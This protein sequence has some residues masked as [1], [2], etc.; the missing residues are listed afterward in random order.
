MIFLF[1]SSIIALGGLGFL[2]GAGL[3]YASKKF[4]VEVDPKVELVQD[5]LPN[6]NCGACG[7][8]GCAAFAEA[9]VAG[10]VAPNKCTPG[11]S[12]TAQRISDI[13]GVS[14]V[15][16]EEPRVAVLQCQGGNKEAPDKFEY[17][18]INDCQAA[19]MI[20]GGAKAC[21]YGCLGLGSCV[22]ACLFDALH[23]ND[24]GLP[25]VDEDKCTACGICV[26]TCPRNI[27]TLIPRSQTVYLGCVSQDKAKAVKS[28]CKVGCFAC[29][30]CT[31]PK[32]TPSG[33]IIMEE[34]LPVIQDITHEE[35]Y[36]AAKKC[37]TK[38]Y[39]IRIKQKV[40]EEQKPEVQEKKQ[41]EVKQ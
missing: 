5:V 41:E 25:V 16:A 30:I 33:C 17:Q 1:V 10:R 38:S 14:G 31:I 23:M 3:A 34:N 29:K 12:E 13:L 22:R 39:V 2:F 28:V 19:M 27:F 20:A 35:L 8:P 15:E 21:K 7:Q 18:G 11:G 32:V 9:V 24:N 36:E 40:T 26:T 4:S 6:A 37:P